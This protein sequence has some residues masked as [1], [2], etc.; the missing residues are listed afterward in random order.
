MPYSGSASVNPRAAS[1]RSR[2]TGV[3]DGP[4]HH[5]VGTEPRSRSAASSSS[6]RASIAASSPASSARSTWLS[7]SSGR[8]PATQVASGSTVTRRPG[9]ARDRR[10]CRDEGRLRLGQAGRAPAASMTVCETA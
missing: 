5:V 3:V 8:P 1:R 2:S 10:E 4:S 6:I 9:Q 7:P